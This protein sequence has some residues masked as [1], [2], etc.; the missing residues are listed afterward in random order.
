LQKEP[1]SRSELSKKLGH[2]K[3]SGQL[4]KILKSLLEEGV[5]AYTIPEKPASRLQKYKLNSSFKI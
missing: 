2:K 4:N 5:V 3:I 1:L